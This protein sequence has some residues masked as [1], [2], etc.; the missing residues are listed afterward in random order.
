LKIHHRIYRDTEALNKTTFESVLYPNIGA[1]IKAFLL[2]V[3]S[4]LKKES[5]GDWN[6]TG[7]L[8][9]AHKRM[10]YDMG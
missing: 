3:L 9:Y 10:K 5:E 7:P 8:F 4:K 2:M 6:I 1:T